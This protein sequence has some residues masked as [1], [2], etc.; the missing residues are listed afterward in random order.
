VLA[1]VW[2]WFTDRWP[3]TA[4]V[5]TAFKEDIPGGSSFAY[6]FGSSA[7]F[8]FSLQAITGI[9]QLFY[10]VPSV[11]H[12]YN[13]LSYLRTE[14]PF[15]WL[16]HGLHFWGAT[17]MVVLVV[18][19][20]SRVY[21]W[22]AF[23]KPREVTWLIGVFLFLFTLG[24]MFTGAPLP[25]DERG[26]WATEVGT[27]MA[28][29]VPYI[30]DFAKRMLRGAESMGQ[31]TLSRFFIIHVAILPGLLMAFI[32]L[33]LVAFRRFGSVGPWEKKKR[34]RSGPFWPDQV[35]K[36]M[37]MAI[38]FFMIVVALTVWAGAPFSG[39]A[40]PIDTTYQPKP[41][42]NFL[43]IYQALKYFKG[44]L[45]PVGT[46]GL[47][48][49]GI[50]LFVLVP[51]LG[52]KEERNPSK[53]PLGMATF[54]IVMVSI[55]MLSIAGYVSKP[56]S[57]G[58]GAPGSQAAPRVK[59]S[60]S[61]QEGARLFRSRGCSSCHAING[62]G[63]HVGPDL[64]NEA[65]RGR[66][67]QWLVDLLNN[68]KSHFP[69]TVM[70]SF[71]SHLSSSQ[72]DS[73]VDYLMSLGASSSSA[74]NPSGTL[75]QARTQ[76]K[77]GAPS[78]SLPGEDK[79]PGHP[80]SETVLAA[81]PSAS[82]QESARL[83]QSAGCT[84]CHMINGVGGQMGPD[85]SDEARRGRSRQWLVDQISDPKSHFP[86]TVMPAFASRLSAGQIDRLV[87]YLM[88][89]GI[90]GTAARAQAQEQPGAPAPFSSLAPEEKQ[91][92]QAAGIIG[93]VKLGSLLFQQ[94]CESCHGAGGTDKVP[95]PGSTDG[96]VP[97][98]NP[99]DREI[100]NLDP[101]VFA[102]NIDQFIQHGSVPQGPNPVLRMLA[103]GDSNAL[104]QQQASNIEA[105][106]L[107]LN[108]IDR[109]KLMH[110]GLSPQ[111]FL[112]LTAVVFGLGC[113]ALGILWVW[114]RK[115]TGRIEP[116][117]EERE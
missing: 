72:I 88:T 83:F 19:H 50:L 4:V 59:P 53:R 18:I 61:A 11:D 40:D 68:P 76:G 13:S 116:G 96:T 63:G 22:G 114:P 51:L 14:V 45:E 91:P 100:F 54:T 1:H 99:I 8:I 97:P 21:I 46:V 6:S 107:S 95:N 108:G 52:R 5:R 109:A 71:S 86:R 31:L 36:D 10:Y 101:Q 26:Y 44:K 77:P 103:F 104:T 65:Q 93:N 64:A 49:V 29:T 92:G 117:Q 74:A 62:V 112:L 98:L 94:F 2:K 81:K 113:L 56:G 35:F 32:V 75:S 17:A 84:G 43:F 57:V 47:P 25:W 60:A 89:L 102:D 27:S 15:G 7:L 9:F 90:S 41:E 66:S 115:R 38:L 106:I 39:A 110:P 3:I 48:M 28:S 78:S 67:R 80:A 85:L 37:V 42:W 12:A 34:E 111:R 30:G 69:Q 79:Q 55:I 24:M 23:K 33:H 73:V 82:A 105:Y 87:D 20:L 58:P 70:A 16:I